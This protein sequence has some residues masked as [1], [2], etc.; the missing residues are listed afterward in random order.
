MTRPPRPR[1]PFNPNGTGGVNVS[2]PGPHR[3]PAALDRPDVVVWAVIGVMASIGLTI[4]AGLSPVPVPWWVWTVTT[5]NN[6]AT[7]Y[8]CGSALGAVHARR[9]RR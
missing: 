5:T 9:W 2:S 7:G 3:R 8:L 4:L 6:V 1:P